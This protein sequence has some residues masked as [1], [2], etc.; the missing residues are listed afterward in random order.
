MAST[1]EMQ[2]R[3]KLRKQL[4]KGIPVYIRK[5]PDGD[6][7]ATQ[8]QSAMPKLNLYKTLD[9]RKDV[10]GFGVS[11][12]LPE[13]MQAYTTEVCN[14][15][16]IRRGDQ[17]PCD[18]WMTGYGASYMSKLASGTARAYEFQ[19][20]AFADGDEMGDMLQ[21][22]GTVWDSIKDKPSQT[23]DEKMLTAKVLHSLPEHYKKLFVAKYLKVESGK[24]TTPV[25]WVSDDRKVNADAL[26]K[27]MA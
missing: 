20:N 7:Y 26:A 14:V 4:A 15:A 2:L 10:G 17:L 13:G 18:A 19:I 1:K 21:I 25:G 22:F 9:I 11:M 27:W 16:V 24:A 5:G 3:A 6:I 12:S 23:F 8:L